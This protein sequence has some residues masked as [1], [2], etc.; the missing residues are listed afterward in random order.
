MGVLEFPRT[1]QGEGAWGAAWYGGPQ[2]GRTQLRGAG[3]A[4]SHKD[5]DASPTE[6][7]RHPPQSQ[8]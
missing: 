3:G 7:T 2:K 4:G 5:E 8:S 1:A 6:G